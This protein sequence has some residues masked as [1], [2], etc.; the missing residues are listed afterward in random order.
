MT[1][2]RSA[3]ISQPDGTKLDRRAA[4]A[5]GEA[6]VG[7]LAHA[8]SSNSPRKLEVRLGRD[9]GRDDVGGVKTT[10][11]LRT[12]LAGTRPGDRVLDDIRDA[13]NGV[14][15]FRVRD[16]VLWRPC[17][18]ACAVTDIHAALAGLPFELRIALFGHSALPQQPRAWHA[19][20]GALAALRWS[21]SLE[22]LAASVAL[23]RL[24]TL[25]D[26]ADG[27]AIAALVSF[28]IA[29]HVAAQPMYARDHRALRT[30]LLETVW[31][32]VDLAGVALRTSA[33][34]FDAAL[35]LAR[36][37]RP[38]LTPTPLEV[39]GALHDRIAAARTVGAT[40]AHQVPA[41]LPADDHWHLEAAIALWASGLGAAIAP[42]LRGNTTCDS[43]H[44]PASVLACL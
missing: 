14:D 10:N 39:Y 30:V 33:D 32:R 21:P 43:I 42:W 8:W 19:N 28:E 44:L 34:D 1:R 16:H 2:P 27:H 37:G 3:C 23:A 35:E 17:D 36:R 9:C 22:T 31:S 38:L 25:R 41:H 24:A 29:A 15:L 6:C 5:R 18:P 11:L 20:P 7:A 26:D 4:R 13:E 12:W 40:L